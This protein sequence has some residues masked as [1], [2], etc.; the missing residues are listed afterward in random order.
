MMNMT[1]NRL[2]IV[3]SVL[4]VLLLAWYTIDELFKKQPVDVETASSMATQA[5]RNAELMQEQMEAALADRTRNEQQ[6]RLDSPRGQALFRRC[7]DW[8]EMLENH[9]S[10][11]ARTRRDEACGELRRFVEGA[12]P[13]TKIDDN[14]N[15]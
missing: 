5:E 12:E 2:L 4:A 14:P 13:A 11:S 8:S 3:A 7:S 10:D 1:R 6:E 9:P 15:H